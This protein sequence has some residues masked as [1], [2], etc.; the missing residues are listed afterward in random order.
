MSSEKSTIRIDLLGPLNIEGGDR[1]IRLSPKERV[2]LIALALRPGKAVAVTQLIDTLWDQDPPVSADKTLQTY[3][4]GL[5][6]RLPADAL[7]SVPNGYTLL[8][9]PDSVDAYRFESLLRTAESKEDEGDPIG[10][11]VVIAEAFELWRGP[12]ML[13]GRGVPAIDSAAERFEELRRGAVE[14]RGRLW[15]LTNRHLEHVAEFERS[16]SEEPFREQR[17]AQLMIALY[18]SGRQTDALRAFQRLS[19]VLAD[20]L[21][22][23]PSPELIKLDSDILQQSSEVELSGFL[24]RQSR[25]VVNVR[26]A[27]EILVRTLGI[28]DGEGPVKGVLKSDSGTLVPVGPEGLRVGRSPE[29]DLVLDDPKVSRNHASIHLVE[30]GFTI[31]DHHS[32]NG[33]FLDGLRVRDAMELP[34]R[35]TVR[36]GDSVFVFEERRDQR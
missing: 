11:C 33:T 24:S 34:D 17:W 30:S 25:E 27:P 5:R 2:L 32:T 36:F 26:P 7:T 19:S 35:S 13:D 3:V 6:R 15:L 12:A 18:R 16:V 28:N 9:E 10:A 8:L 1:S 23:D 4:S 14:N 29:N 31:A 20:E 21:G 22:I